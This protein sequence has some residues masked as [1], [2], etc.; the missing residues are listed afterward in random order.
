MAKSK[1][2]LTKLSTNA[3]K[4]DCAIVTLTFPINNRFTAEFT[5]AFEK[6]LEEHLAEDKIIF[7]HQESNRYQNYELCLNTA[8]L[9]YLKQLIKLKPSKIKEASK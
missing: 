3:Y 2:A 5:A 7:D 8:D 4:T 1:H 9:K 6:F